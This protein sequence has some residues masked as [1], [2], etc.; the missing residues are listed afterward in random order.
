MPTLPLSC[1]RSLGL[2]PMIIAPSSQPLKPRIHTPP[3][4]PAPTQRCVRASHE[5]RS[6][7]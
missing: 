7:G 2:R 5:R 6:K 1:P 3:N 4:T